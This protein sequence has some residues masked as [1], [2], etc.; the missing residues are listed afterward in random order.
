LE[1]ERFTSYSRLVAWGRDAGVLPDEQAVALMDE[2]KKNPA[3]AEA[4]LED[5]TALREAI[6]RLFVTIIGGQRADPSAV[7]SLN[8]VLA[9]AL[10]HRGLS[11]TETGF[12]W[13]WSEGSPSPEMPLWSVALSAAELLVS[14]DVQR[15][16][17]CEGEGC[18][19]L[20][21]DTGRG[22]GRRWCDMAHCGN[23]AKARRHYRRIRA[24]RSEPDC[25]T[26]ELS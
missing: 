18:G 12:D 9:R 16:R 25:R 22:P 17:Q 11:T 24:A 10:T 13:T 15:V 26:E 20:F 1:Y 19:F 8:A 3:A 21:L 2:A 6:H 23:R 5:A 14:V 7:A 4:A